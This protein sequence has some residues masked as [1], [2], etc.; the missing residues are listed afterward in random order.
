MTAT[1]YHK[2]AQDFLDKHGLTFTAKKVGNGYI[3]PGK[4]HCP[5]WGN[6]DWERRP[7]E[8]CH[9][10]GSVHGHKYA[11]TIAANG[12]KPFKFDFWD[13]YANRDRNTITPYDALACISG[14]VTCPDTF[15]AF[16]SE[17]GFCEDSRRDFA[18]YQR[19]LRFA[20]KAKAFFTEEE[21]S[22]LSEIN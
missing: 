3:T 4:K 5:P 14:D 8:G 17:L 11:V 2:Q 10:C 12:R 7:P 19:V 16:C 1:D 18:M 21:L 22:D 9:N 20:A 15:S 6:G 13:S